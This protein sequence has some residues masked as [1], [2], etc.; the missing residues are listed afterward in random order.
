PIT[1]IGSHTPSHHLRDKPSLPSLTTPNL[2]LISKYYCHQIG[3]TTLPRLTTV[4]VPVS[5]IPHV[6]H[7][8]IIPP[9]VELVF[10]LWWLP[11][12]RRGHLFGL[13]PS[14]L[15]QIRQ[16]FNGLV[17]TANAACGLF[18]LTVVATT[19]SAYSA[20]QVDMAAAKAAPRSW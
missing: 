14:T 9:N 1:P 8:L 15:N 10:Y 3:I 20:L 17:I 13:I 19:P 11:D 5:P 6:A 18:K 2:P 4:Q 7:D 12:R 16:L